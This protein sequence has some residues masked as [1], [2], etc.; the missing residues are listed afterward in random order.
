MLFSP[1]CYELAEART[2]AFLLVTLILNL[3]RREFLILFLDVFFVI[4]ERVIN[5]R[6]SK[7]DAVRNICSSRFSSVVYVLARPLYSPHTRHFAR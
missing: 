3:V 7:Y 2:T 6:P 5:G 1:L 4:F